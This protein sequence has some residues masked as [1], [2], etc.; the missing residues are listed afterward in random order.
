MGVV[1]NRPMDFNV[2]TVLVQLD[3]TEETEL[4]SMPVYFGGPVQS[5]RGYVLHDAG[6]TW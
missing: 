3:A 2:G 1:V 5:D 6:S 4:V